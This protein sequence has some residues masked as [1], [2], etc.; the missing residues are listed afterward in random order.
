MANGCSLDMLLNKSNIMR[1]Y[2]L[3]NR[4]DNIERYCS[5]IYVYNNPL[6]FMGKDRQKAMVYT[7][8]ELKKAKEHFENCGIY[9]ME[10]QVL[11]SHKNTVDLKNDARL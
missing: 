6:V 10:K 8:K 2:Q 5:V 9:V 4:I 7:E 3:V 11:I 1:K